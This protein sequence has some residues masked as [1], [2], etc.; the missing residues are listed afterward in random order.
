MSFD[1]VYRISLYE[2]FLVLGYKPRFEVKK[3]YNEEDLAKP[4]EEKRP[5]PGRKKA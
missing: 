2:K 4:A 3:L 5:F 1:E